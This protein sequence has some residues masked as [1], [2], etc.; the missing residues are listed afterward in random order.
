MSALIY[1]NGQYHALAGNKIVK[2]GVAITMKNNDQIVADHVA[3]PLG[4]ASAG[5]PETPVI[6]DAPECEIA[7][8]N[9]TEPTAGT[10]RYI[11][12]NG[13]GSMDGSS[14][15]NAANMSMIHVILLS[16]ASGDRVYFSEGDYTTDRTITLPS[17]VSLFGGFTTENP[18]WATRDAFAHPTRWTASHSGAWLESTANIAGQVVDGFTLV[19]YADTVSDAANITFKNGFIS[20]GSFAWGGTVSNTKGILLK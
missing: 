13:A 14:W 16:S 12:P 9:G 1:S 4:F 19:D 5:T 17:G 6:P 8:Q 10:V 15:E 11:T 18:A 7:H 20:G 2:N 3:Y